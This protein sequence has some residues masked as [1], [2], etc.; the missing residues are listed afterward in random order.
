MIKSIIFD[1]DGVLVDTKDIHFE[2]LNS[3][4]ERSKSGAHISYE[5]HV[6]R[7]DGLPSN[8]KIRILN[9]E[10]RVNPKLNK[11]IKKLKQNITEIILLKE[12]KPSKKITNLFQKLHKKYKLAIAT[13]AV[14]STLDIC[15][16][17]LKLEKYISFKISNEEVK[18]SKP[19]PEIYMQTMIALGSMP[20][21]TLIVEDSYVGRSAA[22]A[23]GGNLFPIK[24]LS[25]LSYK[26][27]YSYIKFNHNSSRQ[28]NWEDSNMNVLIPMA[29]E[30]SRFKEA[31]FTFPK[32]LIEI[33]SKPMIQWVIENLNIKA[34][35][36]F[37]IRKEHQEKFNIKSVLKV[38]EPNCKIIEVDSLTEGA[39]CTT[40]LAEEYI[41]NDQPLILANS[42]QFIEWN[43]SKT[44]YNFISKDVDGGILTFEAIHPKWSYAKLGEDDYVCEV[45][46]KNVISNNA[47]VGIYYWKN[48]S[49]YVH[50]AKQMI[51]KNIRVNNEFYV[52]PVYNEAISDNKKIKIESIKKMW[53][54]GTPEDLNYFLQN[55]TK[56]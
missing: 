49:D 44:M 2:A 19:H 40:L 4:L 27:L 26:S 14:K 11:K 41:N 10:G 39:A 54:L 18:F 36:I 56:K 30:G 5:E 55:Y 21:E 31:G 13:N 15:C 33:H 48:G 28:M 22:Q 17:Q 34:N 9:N 12:V 23:S 46:E 51:K 43:S 32:P 50:Y 1:L 35:F 8:E 45:A 53:G 38:L 7:F 3:A 42:D 6:K 25:D 37:I 20:S 47:T 16:K 29:G 52:C 24:K